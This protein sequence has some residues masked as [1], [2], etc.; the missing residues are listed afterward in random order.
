MLAAAGSGGR[1]GWPW[2]REL[3]RCNLAVL[4]TEE[5]AY[6]QFGDGS[7]LGFDLAADGSWGT[8]CEDPARLHALAAAM[9]A[10]RAEHA[11]RTMTGFVLTDGGIGRRPLVFPVFTVGQGGGGGGPTAR[12]VGEPDCQQP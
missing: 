5:A 8:P 7:W 6:V 11:E 4:R 12:S 10:W 9:L 1:A 3:D 2:Q